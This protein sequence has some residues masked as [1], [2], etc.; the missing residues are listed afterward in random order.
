MAGIDV[1]DWVTTDH[2]A[3]PVRRQTGRHSLTITEWSGERLRGAGESLGVWLMS[4][5]AVEGGDEVPWSI[6]LKGWAAGASAA[7]PTDWDWPLRELELYRSG[8]LQNL[9][10]GATAPRYFGDLQRPDGSI[11]IWLEDVTGVPAAPWSLERYG[12]I[13]R[14][15]GQFNGAYLNG[16]PVPDAPYLSRSWLRQWVEMA[17]PTM[18]MLADH[19]GDPMVHDIFP[20]HVIEAL[21]GLWA[22]RHAT[23]AFLARSPQ[24]FC[25]LDVFRKNIFY[26]PS[27]NGS[28]RTVLVDWSFTGIAAL[29][30]ETAPLVAASVA[31]MEVPIAD[32]RQL[33]ELVLDAYLDGLLDAGWTADPEVIRDVYVASVGLRYGVSPVRFI[34]P[35]MLDRTFVPVIEQML[36]HPIEK[37]VANLAAFYEWLA[38]RV[39]T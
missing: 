11:W 14:Q 7:A 32:I 13:A 19:V 12:V 31:F 10:G 29:G 4:G 8:I 2:I 34:L 24:T 21:L 35:R 27:P 33:E 18:D 1:P 37:I 28:G 3:P 30:E 26:H 39:R 6:V 36:G 25:H 5:S 9:P 15:L 16:H 23:Y 38:R 17:G 22:D 20:P